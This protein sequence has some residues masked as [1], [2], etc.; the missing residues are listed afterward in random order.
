MTEEGLAVGSLPEETH[1]PRRV[2]AL[3][4]IVLAAAPL[5]LAQTRRQQ[6]GADTTSVSVHVTDENNRPVRG[7]MVQLLSSFGYVIFQTFTN[8]Q[9]FADLSSVTEGRYRVRA[10]G[11]EIEEAAGQEFLIREGQGYYDVMLSVRRRPGRSSPSA[12]G[13][14]VDVTD[15]NVPPKAREE[16]DKGT[17]A[18]N[19]NELQKARDHFDRAIRAY[20]EYA[21]AY[22]NLGIAWL[23]EGHT[24][25]GNAALRKAIS[26]NPHL[27]DAYRNLARLT[28]SQGNLPETEDLIRQSLKD[29]P[30]DVEGLAL[31]SKVQLTR[32]EMDEAIANAK[33]V[34]AQPHERYAFVHFI[35]ASALKAKGKDQEAIQ[36]YNTFLKEAP[37][38]ASAPAARAEIQALQ[39]GPH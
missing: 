19:R 14:M 8:D 21:K 36:E 20:P 9:G 26:L 4:L 35:A 22:N 24:E 37:N 6:I 3:V 15:L 29:D 2:L 17:E 13:N 23:R 28:F 33:K 31:L 38:H 34:H 12:S 7:V 18:L 39:A 1:M 32:G 11:E 27:T 30:N 16:C 10:S 25:E 5:A